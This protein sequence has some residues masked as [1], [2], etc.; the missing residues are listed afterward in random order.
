MEAT[1]KEAIERTISE[2]TQRYC[3]EL[4]NCIF[5]DLKELHREPLGNDDRDNR[6]GAYGSVIDL[7]CNDIQYAGKM[8]HSI[9]FDPGTDPSYVRSILTK[10]FE[11]IKIIR[12]MDHPNVVKFQGIYYQQDSLLP[13]LVMEKMECD[14]DQYLT[15]SKKGSMPD[16]IILRILLDVSKGLVYLHE[17]M[18]VAHR[19]LSS[20]NILLTTKLSAKIADFGS[21]RVL[22]KPGGWNVHSKLTVKPGTL[23]FMPPEALEEPPQYTV[24]VDIFSFGC[25]IIHVCTHTWP[26]PIGRTNQERIVSEFERRQKYILKI[27]DVSLIPI[28]KQCLEDKSIKRPTARYIKSLLEAK[29]LEDRGTLTIKFYV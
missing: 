25:V 9:F 7:E 28:I 6:A 18:K 5:K 26:S 29:I 16:Y 20:K 8:L 3:G 23:D 1:K 4:K 10:F 2:V 14:L 17:E 19:D 22:D 11:E 12:K 21:A 24:S 27:N 15:T 13:V